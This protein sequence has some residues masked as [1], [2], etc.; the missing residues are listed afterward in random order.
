MQRRLRPA[1]PQRTEK[2][3]VTYSIS[4]L[5]GVGFRDAPHLVS[6]ADVG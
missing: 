6:L 2:R 5:G 3:C 1:K 4:Y